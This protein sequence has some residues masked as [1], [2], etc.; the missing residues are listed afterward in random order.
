MSPVLPLPRDILPRGIQNLGA[1]RPA[2]IRVFAA[3][4]FVGSGSENPEYHVDPLH[5]NRN[6]EVSPLIELQTIF[7]IFFHVKNKNNRVAM[8]TLELTPKCGPGQCWPIT[9]TSCK[10]NVW[11]K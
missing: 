7:A 3:A 4:G 1:A 2:C 11:K 6:S 5:H 10:I 8:K 9:N